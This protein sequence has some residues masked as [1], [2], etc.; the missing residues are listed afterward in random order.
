M[1]DICLVEILIL[2]T[3]ASTGLPV[4]MGM[5]AWSPADS[6]RV[7]RP[8]PADGRG[9]LE[10]C[11]RSTWGVEPGVWGALA[12]LQ[13]GNLLVGPFR[14]WAG[15]G[16]GLPLAGRC[17]WATPGLACPAKPGLRLEWM[18]R[19]H[20]RR[21]QVEA[22]LGTSGA[23]DPAGPPFSPEGPPRLRPGV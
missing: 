10:P 20:R 13:A 5:E 22:A 7:D 21:R 6:R 19:V 9:S 18:A 3:A 17:G 4:Q 14:L 8:P 1:L 2:L 12:P 15:L 23:Y 11:R 16:L